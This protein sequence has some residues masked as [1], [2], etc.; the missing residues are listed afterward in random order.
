M[1]N[2][3][4]QAKS[5]L[6]SQPQKAY[7]LLSSIAATCYVSD[8]SE[9]MYWDAALQ[10]C[11]IRE[12]AH[13]VRNRFSP[14]EVGGYLVSPDK[15]IVQKLQKRFFDYAIE[16]N[17]EENIDDEF[18]ILP[19]V[20][21]K[22]N[23]FIPEAYALYALNHDIIIHLDYITKEQKLVLLALRLKV[24]NSLYLLDEKNIENIKQSVLF[25]EKSIFLLTELEDG[26]HGFTIRQ[27]RTFKFTSFE[28]LG[29]RLRALS[30]YQESA[31]ALR[32]A[33]KNA[34]D[35]DGI[36]ENICGAAISLMKVDKQAALRELDGI[37]ELTDDA[38]QEQVDAWNFLHAQLNFE[39]KEGTSDVIRRGSVEADILSTIRKRL[40]TGKNPTSKRTSKLVSQIIN[41]I[42]DSSVESEYDALLLSV[43]T[44][45]A[46]RDLKEASN[47]LEKAEQLESRLDDQIRK[48]R[49]ILLQLRVRMYQ[50]EDVSQD[51]T[52]CFQYF[53]S[54][55]DSSELLEAYKH[56]IEAISRANR[57][58]YKA[59][60][61]LINDSI[62]LLI[63]ELL[64]Q[65]NAIARKRIREFNQDLVEICVVALVLKAEYEGLDS[66]YSQTLFKQAVKVILLT[67]NIE[68]YTEIKQVDSKGKSLEEAFYKTLNKA[69]SVKNDDS[70]KVDLGA[71]WDYE[72]RHISHQALEISRHDENG[73][74]G[75]LIYFVVQDLFQSKL[76]LG[77]YSLEGSIVFF[78]VDDFESNVEKPITEYWSNLRLN[79][80]VC[81]H[82]IAVASRKLFFGDDLQFVLKH[83]LERQLSIYTDYGMDSLGI[84]S[85]AITL[86]AADTLPSWLSVSLSRNTASFSQ[87]DLYRGFLGVGGVPAYGEIYEYLSFSKEEIESISDDV[88]KT[89]CPTSHL[90]GTD[91]TVHNVKDVV[92]A[93]N[94]AILHFAV[95]GF[96]DARE[97]S[98]ISHLVLAE[99]ELPRKFA[100]LS[101]RQ[102]IQW[103]LA[104]VDLVVLSACSTA[105][106]APVRGDN[107][108]SLVGAFLR[109]GVKSVIASHY[110]V[111]DKYTFSFMRTFYQYLYKTNEPSKALVDAKAHC[112][113]IGVPK[114][115]VAAWSIYR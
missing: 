112:L 21:L 85:L 14:V 82:D 17:K 99:S 60:I 34:D 52:E 45:L 30:Q 98:D 61:L 80:N 41:F 6:R 105:V 33:A 1:M 94:P 90:L 5:I 28:W 2:E 68:L 13:G 110:P 54:Y 81:N 89:G 4:L 31:T 42:D 67:R 114:Y 111:D 22:R 79:K 19:E 63:S 29:L 3:I 104:G 101:Y 25:F 15:R 38:S 103:D 27:L 24:A 10:V 40:Y 62:T 86:D 46:A 113:N 83:E 73:H 96:G 48:Y 109:A 84:D 95:H 50:G 26:A 7:K 47:I 92:Q 51:F 97:P 93:R 66:E 87:V 12:L 115:Q 72:S 37:K 35:I 70:W 74:D 49:R 39:L 102:I 107:T 69:F 76:L 20:S 18:V 77:F 44:V 100:L 65:S 59:L 55:F 16:N 64:N 11:S 56:Y 88:A 36:V 9:K 53:S 106:G 71:L 58:D 75:S 57:L 108:R 32:T 43:T 78:R 23:R 8:D 91:A